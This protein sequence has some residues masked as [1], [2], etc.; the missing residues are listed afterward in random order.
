MNRRTEKLER[1]NTP[2]IIVAGNPT[3]GFT[4]IGPFDTG[5]DAVTYMESDPE[6]RRG[7]A[8]V[9]MLQIPAGENE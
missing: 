6:L 1:E 7:N 8:W 3:D 9:V 4:H 2:H 5:E